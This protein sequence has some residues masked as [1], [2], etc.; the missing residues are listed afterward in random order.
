MPSIA[1]A[2]SHSKGFPEGS[3]P[4]C[5]RITKQPLHTALTFGRAE[6]VRGNVL[7]GVGVEP[8]KR[9]RVNNGAEDK[10]ADCSRGQKL[11]YA[12]YQLFLL[13]RFV[14]F[15]ERCWGWWSR[16]GLLVRE[17]ESVDGT[18]RC[19]R[20][21]AEN[22]HWRIAESPSFHCSLLL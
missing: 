10:H 13:Q 16:H 4:A 22:S 21:R 6:L 12:L 5:V 11:K 9:E 19:R 18:L 7:G 3:L 15:P 17:R 2:E 1:D 8:D 14:A 20:G